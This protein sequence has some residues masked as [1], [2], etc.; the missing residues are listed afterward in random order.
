MPDEKSNG[1]PQDLDTRPPLEEWRHTVFNEHISDADR[2]RLLRITG[3]SFEIPHLRWASVKASA[4]FSKAAGA[5]AALAQDMAIG[6]ATSTAAAYRRDRL[7]RALHEALAEALRDANVQTKPRR[8]EKDPMIILVLAWLDM[9]L[10]DVLPPRAQELRGPRELAVEMASLGMVQRLVRYLQP[11]TWSSDAAAFK[12]LT[13]NLTRVA[14]W[15]HEM[16]GP[17]RA[18]H[19]PSLRRDEWIQRAEEQG[20]NKYQLAALLA[21][22]GNPATKEAP[23]FPIPT[24]QYR[25]REEFIDAR[26]EW[27]KQQTQKHYDQLRQVGRQ[28]AKT[29]VKG[30]KVARAE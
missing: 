23:P 8:L 7:Q 1:S 22:A 24:I 28:K 10:A 19:R 9:R 20:L 5:A 29:A 26:D 3:P 6:E 13:D 4:H 17:K 16:A 27:I 14:R 30:R 11:D 12:R 15:Y 2:D 18:A 21:R 25:T